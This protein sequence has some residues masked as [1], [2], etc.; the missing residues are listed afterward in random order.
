MSVG[1]WVR[2]CVCVLVRVCVGVVRGVRVVS[3]WVWVC[4]VQV[5]VCKYVGGWVTSNYENTRFQAQGPFPT[6]KEPSD[7]VLIAADLVI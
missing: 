7:H 6:E 2:G 3:V 4:G 5:C 1:A